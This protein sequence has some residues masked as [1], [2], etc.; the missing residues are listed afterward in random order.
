M[1][2]TV[3]ISGGPFTQMYTFKNDRASSFSRLDYF[4]TSSFLLQSMHEV[5]MRLGNWSGK[6]DHFESFLA[7]VKGTIDLHN[8]T[9]PWSI[10]QPRLLNLSAVQKQECKARVVGYLLPTT[11]LVAKTRI[12]LV[13]CEI[14]SASR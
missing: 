5:R 11:L 9:Q 14:K 10:F 8:Q 4:L 12:S 13:F 6:L 3:L 2:G 1:K 7:H